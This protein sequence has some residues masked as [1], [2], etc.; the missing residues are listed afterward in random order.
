MNISGI[1]RTGLRLPR[2]L[3]GVAITGA[4][5][6]PGCYWAD[7]W[8]KSDGY[9]SRQGT[10]WAGGAGA[11]KGRGA[12]MFIGDVALGTPYVSRSSYSGIKPPHGFHS[13]AGLAGRNSVQNNEWVVYNTDQQILRYLVEYSTK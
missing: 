4:Y 10:Y 3:V 5:L 9:T 6:G 12:F 1:L 7:D 11:I 2:E 13:V 8:R